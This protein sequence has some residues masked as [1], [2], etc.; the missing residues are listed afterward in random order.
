QEALSNIARHARASNVWVSL[1]RLHNQV[2]LRIR[3]DGSGFDA[4]GGSNGM[5]LANMRARA[6]EFGGTFDLE[7]KLGGTVLTLSI[8]CSPDSLSEFRRRALWLGAILIVAVPYAF[9]RDRVFLTAWVLV[10]AA[11][12]ARRLVGYLRARKQSETAS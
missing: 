4:N 6:E 1:D 9:W 8:P 3:D 11:G 2:E 5:G 7:S 12:F 10:I